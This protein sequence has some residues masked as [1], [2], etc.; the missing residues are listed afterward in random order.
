MHLHIRRLRWG[1]FL[2]EGCNPIMGSIGFNDIIGHKRYK[3]DQ[4]PSTP[5]V[6]LCD[7]GPDTGHSSHREQQK[8]T[9]LLIMDSLEA[10]CSEIL[11]GWVAL[12]PR[13]AL[14]DWTAIVTDFTQSQRVAVAPQVAST[15]R[16]IYQETRL[17]IIMFCLR[18]PKST[19]D[20]RK[21]KM[22]TTRQ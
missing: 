19:F 1:H 10:Y 7:T 9:L 5:C 3:T 15:N 8:Y 4:R 6:P 11:H 16:M 14:Y 18:G 17:Q 13:R 12:S 20:A 21:G 2:N 22:N